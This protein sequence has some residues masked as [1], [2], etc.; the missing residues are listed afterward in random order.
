M[1]DK[2]NQEIIEIRENKRVSN[3]NTIESYKTLRTNLLY[4]DNLKVITIT[5]TVPEEGKTVT[6][7]NLAESYAQ[8]GKKVLLID[9]DL[10]KSTLRKF[11]VLRKTLPGL[12]EVLTRQTSNVIT[13][14]NVNNLFMVLSGKVPPNPSELLSSK[15][16]EDV[17]HQLKAN[18]DYIIIDTPPL[19]VAL[20]AAIVGRI[21]DGVVLVVRNDFVR[22]KEVKRAKN[23]LERN[24]SRIVG[25]VLNRVKKNQADYQSYGYY[26]YR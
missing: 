11:L 18:F 12:S 26:G 2:T 9:C 14:T 19:N 20:D 16:F 24:G 21:S 13:K 22:K 7:F 23:Q 5:S 17:I 15:A 1:D 25:V 8:M 4:T 3:F 6:A 10:R